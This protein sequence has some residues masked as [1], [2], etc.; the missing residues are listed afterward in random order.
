VTS[1]TNDIHIQELLPAYALGCLD[2]DEET[3]VANHLASC[4]L[5]RAELR[6]FQAVT[7]DL[8]LAAP[9]VAPPQHLKRRLMERV[10]PPPPVTP[11]R[12]Q[13]QT[14]WRFSLQ[15]VMPVWA[16]LSLLLILALAAVNLLL[17]QRVN[18]LETA[19]GPG[20][21]QAIPLTSTDAAPDASGYVIISP[22]GRNGA[23]VVDGLPML[24]AEHEY[25][26]WLIREPGLQ[27][28]LFPR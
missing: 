23:I 7:D 3:V 4:S 20:Q 22:D 12:P 27:G 8:A 13:A 9:D 18:Q 5:C 6:I 28:T 14:S 10:Q 15:R 25:Q 2:E 24:D 21:M 16:P 19:A 26:L 1:L 17:W 11:S